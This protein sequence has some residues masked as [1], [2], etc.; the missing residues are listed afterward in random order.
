MHLADSCP[1]RAMPGQLLGPT[2]CRVPHDVDNLLVIG[3]VVKR[4]EPTTFYYSDL[5]DY[6]AASIIYYQ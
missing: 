2:K 1:T 3:R 5:S 4:P 6:E